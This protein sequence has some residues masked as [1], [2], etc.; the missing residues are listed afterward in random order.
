MDL[1]LERTESGDF[2]H[3]PILGSSGA[4]GLEVREVCGTLECL[5]LC[6]HRNSPFSV[7]LPQ[8]ASK[9]P[10]VLASQ[11][12]VIWLRPPEHSEVSP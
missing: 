2:P 3:F 7:L 8:R 10:V 6:T 11:S 5:R 1:P 12:P 4:L 9:T